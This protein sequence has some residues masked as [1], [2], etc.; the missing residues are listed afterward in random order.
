MFHFYSFF[1]KSNL[2]FYSFFLTN[3][4]ESIII[5][6]QEAKNKFK[7]QIKR[8]VELSNQLVTMLKRKAYFKLIEWKNTHKNNCLMVKG[9]RQVGKTYLVREFGKKNTRVSLK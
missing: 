9:A 5:K 3:T 8:S 4:N 2:R 1:A 7:K 6:L